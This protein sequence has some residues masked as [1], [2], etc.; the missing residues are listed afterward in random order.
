MIFLKKKTFKA[1]LSGF[2]FSQ[3]KMAPLPKA[4]REKKWVEKM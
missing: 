3:P 1:L 4:F 2:P